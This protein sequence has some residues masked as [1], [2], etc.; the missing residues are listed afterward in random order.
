MNIMTNVVG[1]GTLASAYVRAKMEV[2]SAGYTE[3]IV[4]QRNV[5]KE[6]YTER[7]FLR[8]CAWVILC[9]GMRET[10]VRQK[11]PDICQAFL[12]WSSAHEIAHRQ[13]ECIAAALVHFGHRGK[14]KAIVDCACIIH[15]KGFDSLR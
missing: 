11:F 12:Y 7:D 10:V 3:E 14:M 6:E 13:S 4:W 8:E 15:E 5:P 2:M 9:S 1:V